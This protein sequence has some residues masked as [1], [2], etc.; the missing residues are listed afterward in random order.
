MGQV[1]ELL[2]NWAALD[3][4]KNKALEENSKVLV[5]WVNNAQNEHLRYSGLLQSTWTPVLDSDGKA[6]LPDDFLRIKRNTV[7]WDENTTLSEVEYDEAINASMTST[8]WYSIHDG[9]FYVFA[10]ASGEPQ[11]TYIRRPSETLVSTFKTDDLDIPLEYQHTLMLFLDAMW[12]RTKG[13]TAGY[14]AL[15]KQFASQAVED[16]VQDIESRHTVPMMRGGML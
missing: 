6:A 9:Y 3:P 8:L 11:I 15:Y 4:E 10:A 1:L 13:D 16:G 14:L 2:A 12:A 5:R 7:K